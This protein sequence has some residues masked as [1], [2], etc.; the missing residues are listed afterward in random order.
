M[1]RKNQEEQVG[2]DMKL[3]IGGGDEG[4]GNLD[5][6]IKGTKKEAIQQDS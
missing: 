1:V 5:V 4:Q 2:G 3:L 6:V